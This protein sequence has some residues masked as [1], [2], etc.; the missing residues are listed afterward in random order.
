MQFLV[1]RDRRIR[2]VNQVARTVAQMLPVLADHHG[3]LANPVDIA[4]KGDSADRAAAHELL[5][6]RVEV[7]PDVRRI[8]PRTEIG[9][10][11]THREIENLEPLEALQKDAKHFLLN[12]VRFD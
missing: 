12:G 10:D 9:V 4:A 1:G 6:A 2:S 11:A 5:Q 3:C 8:M 7:L